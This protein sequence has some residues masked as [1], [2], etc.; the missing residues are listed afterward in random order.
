MNDVYGYTGKIVEYKSIPISGSVSILSK[1]CLAEID[2][3]CLIFSKYSLVS[4]SLLITDIFFFPCGKFF[5]C[6]PP[7]TTSLLLSSCY[8]AKT[9]PRNDVK[10]LCLFL[11]SYYS[12]SLRTCLYEFISHSHSSGKKTAASSGH[13]WTCL[14]TSKTFIPHPA[15]LAQCER[16]GGGKEDI[17]RSFYKFRRWN[18]SVC[19]VS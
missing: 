18:H 17:Y 11:F 4:L 9:D 10:G 3:K 15:S 8:L 13:A 19:M 5:A 12:S 2:W 7:P 6:L 14:G 16:R 1:Y